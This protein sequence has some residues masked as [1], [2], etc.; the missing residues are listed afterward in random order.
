MLVSC[1]GRRGQTVQR[2]P[3]AFADPGAEAPRRRH[4]T[5]AVG[6]RDRGPPCPSGRGGLAAA[7]RTERAA[8]MTTRGFEHIYLE[9]HNWGKAVAFW[10]ALGFKLDFETDHGTGA[11]GS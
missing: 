3:T 8:V 5:V 7:A 6:D 10:Q 11:P 4:R 1:H 9:T 2:L